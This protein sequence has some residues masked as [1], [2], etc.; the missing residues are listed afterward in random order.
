MDLVQSPN[1][2]AF[3]RD[4]ANNRRSD[5]D[6]ISCDIPNKALAYRLLIHFPHCGSANDAASMGV[7]QR[8]IRTVRRRASTQQRELQ[9]ARAALG[10]GE[11]LPSHRM[12]CEHLN[13]WGMRSPI[14]FKL[15]PVPGGS[16]QRDRCLSPLSMH[17]FSDRTVQLLP[18]HSDV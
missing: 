1:T 12:P 16:R 17:L 11:I 9:P 8:N 15:R 14:E 4:L 5:L 7:G 13:N 6:E 10:R 3:P 2:F 18:R